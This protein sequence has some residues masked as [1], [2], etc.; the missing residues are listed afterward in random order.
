MAIT[1]DV[2]KGSPDGIVKTTSTREVGKN[3]AVIKI[4]HSGVCGTDEHVLQQYMGLGHEGVGIVIE[5]GPDVQAVKVGDRIGFGYA[6][7]FCRR[8]EPCLT[9]SSNI[10]SKAEDTGWD[11]YCEN[12]RFY[13]S[14]DRDEG[15]FGTHVV[16]DADSLHTIPDAI[17]SSY[18]GPLM[19]GGA[20]VWAALTMYNVS[21]TD[22]VGVVG[23]GGLGHLAIQ[24]ASKLGCEV[25]VFSGSESKRAEALAFGATEFHV[26][27][28]VKEFKDVKKIKHLLI[29]TS[30]PPDFNLY[31][32]IPLSSSSPF[33]SELILSDMSLLWP[34]Q[35]LYILSLS[36]TIPHLSLFSNSLLRELPFREAL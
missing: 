27:K 8:C 1:F 3:D 24:I 25:V 35:E 6:H 29:T 15:S 21:P 13:I 34:A 26:T 32:P 30:Q 31:F 2:F 36:V 20:T 12:G 11:N 16:L 14:D 10:W 23:I 18:A 5:I 4:T 28:G 17:E 7:Y 33:C 19:C 22:R 9:G